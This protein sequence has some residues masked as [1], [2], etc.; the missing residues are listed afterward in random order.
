[1]L[2]SYKRWARISGLV[3]S[4]GLYERQAAWCDHCN[5]TDRKHKYGLMQTPAGSLATQINC[6]QFLTTFLS[7]YNKLNKASCLMAQF[8]ETRQSY[9]VSLPP[10]RW[11]YPVLLKHWYIC[12][13]VH[14]IRFQARQNLYSPTKNLKSHKKSSACSWRVRHVILFLDPQDE[15]GPS[16]SSSVFLCFFVLL[17]YIIVLVLVVCLC[18]SSV[19]VVATFLC[20]VLFPL[21]C[22]ALQFFA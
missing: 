11:S 15:V 10:W 8:I 22:S 18:P 4:A 3:A 12:T 20:T 5:M 13:E 7:K 17:L 2:V 16:I 9:W 21:L 1:M 6:A 14:V 19:H